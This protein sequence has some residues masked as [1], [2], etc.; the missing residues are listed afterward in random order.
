M[1]S[2]SVY[3]NKFVQFVVDTVDLNGYQWEQAYFVKPA[4]NAI[5]VMPTDGNGLWL[6]NQYRYPAKSYFWQIIMG[7]INP[8][9]TELDCVNQELQEEAGL[10]TSKLI[11][12]GSALAIPGMSSEE[13]FLYVAENVIKTSSRKD[14]TEVGL[15]VK[16]FTFHEITKMIKNG[17]IR[18]GLTLSALF[19]FNIK[20]QKFISD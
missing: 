10:I 17:D 6:V 14:E 9:Q 2:T 20:H 16:Y 19:L 5:G 15:K 1:K 8:G 18:C 3:K 7:M 4:G 11:K 12:I 13:N